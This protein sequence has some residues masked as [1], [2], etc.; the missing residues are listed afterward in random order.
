MTMAQ[1]FQASARE[2][3]SGAVCGQLFGIELEARVP[4][5]LVQ[6]SCARNHARR[7]MVEPSSIGALERRWPAHEAT[8]VLDRLWAPGRVGMTVDHHPSLG[9]RVWASRMGRHLVSLDGRHI[10]SALPRLSPWIW[11]RLLFAQVLPLAATLHGLELLHASA[12]VLDGRTIAFS[13]P[14]GTGK[15]S[16]AAHLVAGGAS[17]LTDDVLAL[18][19]S[20]DMLLA[21]SG[22]PA[23]AVAD[24]ELQAMTAEGQARLGIAIGRID[25]V[26]FR[27]NVVPQARRLDA[28]YFLDRSPDVTLFAIERVDPDP[29]RA[30]TQCFNTYVRSQDRVVT[31]LAV[32]ERLVGSVPMFSVAIPPSYSAHKVAAAVIAHTEVES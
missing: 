31:Q 6:G 24:A 5:E 4:L 14:A 1:A 27:S 22:A 17:L 2:A 30:L 15:T 13:A 32:C 28:L 16:V 9:Y 18:E 11:E 21:H 26:I 8:R 10:V 19:L 12:V 7:T 29:I 25:K 20:N 23:F 3:A